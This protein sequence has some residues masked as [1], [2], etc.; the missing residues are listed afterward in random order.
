[1]PCYPSTMG[2]Q[3]STWPERAWG[4]VQ[5]VLLGPDKRI[6]TLQSFQHDHLTLGW[7][8][9]K[10]NESA[11][12][13][14]SARVPPHQTKLLG[15]EKELSHW[16]RYCSLTGKPSKMQFHLMALQYSVNN[17]DELYFLLWRISGLSGVLLCRYIWWFSWT[18]SVGSN[19]TS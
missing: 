8:D 12:Y 18:A 5:T 10:N 3:P 2:R 17:I 16:W 7:Q 1:M 19:L 15:W 4:T 13:Q 11:L 9:P 6:Y 14:R